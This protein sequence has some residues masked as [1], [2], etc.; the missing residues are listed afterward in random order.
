MSLELLWRAANFIIF[1]KGVILR[2]NGVGVRRIDHDDSPVVDGEDL[3]VSLS[4]PEIH[5]NDIEK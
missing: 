4:L 3:A 1:A 5:G 2:A